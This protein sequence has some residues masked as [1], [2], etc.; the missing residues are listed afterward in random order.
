MI[1]INEIKLSLDE[2]EHPTKLA[3]IIAANPNFIILL[4]IHITLLI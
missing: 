4:F 3:A 2:D 1:R